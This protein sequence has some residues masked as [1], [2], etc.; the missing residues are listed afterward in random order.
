M[1][2]A[3]IAGA[4]HGRPKPGGGFM[5]RCP[6]SG[7]GRGRGDRHPSL[8]ID[9]G[10]DGRLLVTCF[11]GCAPRD[12]LAELARLGL[13]PDRDGTRPAH[14]LTT[15]PRP[16][17]PDPRA[18]GI[19]RASKPI[20]GT[21][22][23]RYLRHRG[24]ALALPPSLRFH[25]G[26]DY[27]E[28]DAAPGG[29][30]TLPALVAGV[31]AP[32]RRL[33]AV[34]RTFLRRDGR[35]KAAVASPKKMLGR[36]ARGSVRFAPAGARLLIGEGLETTLAAMEATG[37][38]AWAALST[39]GLRSLVVPPEVRE[40]VIAAD[41]DRPGVEAAEVAADRWTGE[42]RTVRIARAPDGFD[43]ADVIA[44]RCPAKV[45]GHHD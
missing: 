2:A 7:H 25:P 13:L 29:A 34:H 33:V 21:I 27:F 38:P 17:E 30:I 8:S 26:L 1:A 40:I 23:E 16:T 36:C 42:G 9:D 45:G 4:L 44:G 12:V 18:L 41:G 37:T 20:A 43:F 35:G 6:L 3:E 10:H 19:W 5:A 31:Q 11:A 22:A 15:P 39:S 32:D 24:I 14:A 28:V